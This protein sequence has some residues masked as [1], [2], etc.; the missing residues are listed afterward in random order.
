MDAIV[1]VKMNSCQIDYDQ[2]P[3]GHTWNL[4][5][6][7]TEWQLFVKFDMLL[8]WC[9]DTVT[10]CIAAQKNVAWTTSEFGLSAP[11]CVHLTFKPALRAFHYWV[12]WCGMDVNAK[13]GWSKKSFLPVLCW[14]LEECLEDFSEKSAPGIIANCICAICQWSSFLLSSQKLKRR[15]T[16]QTPVKMRTNLL[17]LES[18]HNILN[19]CIP[20]S[21]I[22]TPLYL[23]CISL[24]HFAEVKLLIQQHWLPHCMRESISAFTRGFPVNQCSQ[25]REWIRGWACTFSWTPPCSLSLLL[26][27]PPLSFPWPLGAE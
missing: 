18:W 3:L 2:T 27:S 19:A 20:Q 1:A 7:Q 10:R 11:E 26:C 6:Q 5:V 13:Q 12:G 22:M 23:R 21:N 14:N 24:R 8:H 25:Q 15:H 4:I 9:H 16:C 17:S